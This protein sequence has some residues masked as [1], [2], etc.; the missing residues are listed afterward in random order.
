MRRHVVWSFALLFLG[1]HTFPVGMP[2][3]AAAPPSTFRQ[4]QA[5]LR[6]GEPERAIALFEQSREETVFRP[7][8]AETGQDPG[9]VR[10]HLALAAAYMETDEPDRA[11]EQLTRFLEARPEHRAARLWLAELHLRLERHEEAAGQ[12]DLA[13]RALQEETQTDWRHLVHCHG[14]LVEVAEKEKDAYAAHL[15]RGIGLYLLALS[16]EPEEEVPPLSREGL[17]CKAAGELTH[18]ADLGPDRARPCW[19]LHQVWRAL[20]QDHQARVWLHKARSQAPFSELTPVEQA[21]L[22]LECRRRE[23]L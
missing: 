17:L 2:E 4:G 20:G 10:H 16:L 15:H 5:A 18:A 9:S 6:V 19:Y 3:P 21:R 7:A 14:R 1:C 22:E 8:V 23:R 11:C 13:I 12:F